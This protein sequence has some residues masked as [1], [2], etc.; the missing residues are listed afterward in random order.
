MSGI[1]Q[2]LHLL[3][4]NVCGCDR[5]QNEYTQK[6]VNLGITVHEEHCA[7][8]GDTQLV[9]KTSAIAKDNLATKQAEEKR[10]PILLREQLLG[11]IFDQYPTRIA[12]CGTHGKTTTTALLHHVLERCGIAHTAFV[13]GS[14]KGENYFA[15]RDV[16][17]AEACEYNKSFL[18]L[19]PTHTLCLN[20]EFDHPD[21]Y[22]DLSDVK[23]AFGQLFAQSKNVILPKS[24]KTL[25]PSGLV[26]DDFV[27]L[28]LE[29]KSPS[30]AITTYTFQ[31][32]F[33][34]RYQGKFVRNCYLQIGGK[35]NVQN[36]LGVICLCKQFNIPLWQATNALCSFV[37]VDRRGTEYPYKC[38][39]VC[40]YA[41]HPTEISA[42]IATA[43]EQTTGKVVCLFQPHTY[44]RTKAF[45]KE[46]ATCFCQTKVFYLPIYSAR[47]K[48]IN[49]V[50]SQELCAFAQSVG[51]D[52]CYLDDF[53]QAT[54]LLDATITPDDTV[55][56]LGAGDV[57]AIA[58]KLSQKYL[59]NCN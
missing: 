49:G 8:I 41:H 45:W 44:S 58:K 7:D 18:Y 21:C 42:T 33:E 56:V 20:I 6:L 38:R 24:E 43:K 3:G 9:V 54:T 14:Y 19:H 47:E 17:I 25:C 4:Y 15:G 5:Q 13:G 28:P 59:G 11:I 16:V 32:A 50:T 23:D 30:S 55:L 48:P 29:N 26:V 46:F 1:A 57:V 40:D 22:Q 31:N 36:A 53:S 52:A 34:L 39:L 27:A 51:I 12:I 37:G 35:H 2:H 10:V